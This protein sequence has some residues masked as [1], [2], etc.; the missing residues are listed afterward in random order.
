[1]IHHLLTTI[2]KLW[3]QLACLS[4]LSTGELSYFL[5]P[6]QFG[7]KKNKATSLAI[8]SFKITVGRYLNE[9]LS[10]YASFL[11]MSTAFERV[12]HELLLG[13]TKKGFPL[14][15]RSIIS[16]IL[17]INGICVY[18]SGKYSSSWR[19]VKG[20]RHEVSHRRIYFVYT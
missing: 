8:F 16:Y 7:Y 20:V 5:S 12:W 18:Y 1:M 11:D 3:Y 17:Q 9:N 4:Y 19:A 15:L 2:E 6:C 13:K 10:V 14:F